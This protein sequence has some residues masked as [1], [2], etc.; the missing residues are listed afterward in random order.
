MKKA[1]VAASLAALFSGASIADDLSGGLEIDQKV[2]SQ[3]AL[4]NNKAGLKVFVGYQDIG[5]SAKR[6]GANNEYNINYTHGFDNFWLKGEGEFVDK[7]NANESDVRKLGVSVGTSVGAFDVSARARN[8]AET[9]R[10]GLGQSNIARFD[11]A[12]GIQ[13]T[14]NVYLNAKVVHQAELDKTTKALNA[15]DNIQNYE[16]RATFNNLNGFKPYIEVGNEGTFSNKNQR[17][18]Y[19][20]VGVVFNF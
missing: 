15:R 11:L 14:D 17:D 20:K 8:D 16:L 2:N 3:G 9:Q 10:I 5:F 18:S 7:T 4:S 6:S 13:A 19:G 1:I 12:A